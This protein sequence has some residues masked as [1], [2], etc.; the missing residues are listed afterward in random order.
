MAGYRIS[1]TLF[2]SHIFL[3]RLYA[4]LGLDNRNSFAIVR[5]LTQMETLSRF[6]TRLFSSR[7]LHKFCL[8]HDILELEWC[9]SLYPILHIWFSWLVETISKSRWYFCPSARELSDWRLMGRFNM[10]LA[11]CRE[12]IDPQDYVN[13]S[14]PIW[15]R[16][17]I[18]ITEVRCSFQKKRRRWKIIN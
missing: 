4:L 14:Y 16:N 3:V 17:Y 7:A 6:S 12:Y 18:S 10:Q 8:L 5:L 11:D 1:K 13:Q 15:N 2:D 9:Y